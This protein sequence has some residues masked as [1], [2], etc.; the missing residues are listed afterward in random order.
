[1]DISFAGI[2]QVAATFEAQEPTGGSLERLEIGMAVALTEA[3]TVGLGASGNSPCGVI[4]ALEK[5]GKAT[6]Q[7]DGFAQV[8][9]SGAS[10]PAVG[11]VNLAVDGAGKVQVA[12][13]GGRSCLVVQV[14]TSA[15]TAV[16]KL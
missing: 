2:G 9:Y 14:D 15:Q 5:D 4:L 12:S 3:N 6:V 13:T 1:M 8:G 16:I 11:W 7:V 10:A